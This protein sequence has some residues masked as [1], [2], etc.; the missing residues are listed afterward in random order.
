MPHPQNIKIEQ[1]DGYITIVYPRYSNVKEKKGSVVILHGMCE[2]H[3]RYYP[4]SNFLNEHGYDV[5]LYDH[6]GHGRDKNLDELGYIADHDGYQILI[7]DGIQVLKYIKKIMQTEQLILVAHS[8]GSLVGRNIIQQYDDIDKAIFLG[9]ANPTANT[10]RF[11]MA[12]SSVIQKFKGPKHISRFLQK[13]MFETK[14]YQRLCER[15]AY[16][17]LTRNNPKVGAYIHDPYCGF[18]AT[19]SFHRDIIHLSYYAGIPKR[20]ARTRKDLPILLASGTKDPVGGYGADVTRLFNRY[21]KLGYK[22]IDCI[23]YE[24]CRHEL[25]NEINSEDIMNDLVKWIDSRDFPIA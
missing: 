9:T 19:T 4:F 15:T 13:N 8:M 22:K 25:L 12:A 6:R 7:Q 20:I 14:P 1:A 10:C 21:Q 5:Y 23:L 24:D 16:D 17:W 18:P 3:E 11:G 2:H